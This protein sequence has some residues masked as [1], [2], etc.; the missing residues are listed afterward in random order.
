M[1]ARNKV[2][3]LRHRR[4]ALAW[5]TVALSV[6]SVPAAITVSPP[7]DTG[8]GSGSN[9]PA[10]A[11]NTATRAIALAE[12]VKPLRLT[13][14]LRDGSRILGVPAITNLQV[15]SSFGVIGIEL[16][17]LQTLQFIEGK[18]ASEFLLQNGDKVS[19]VLNLE[20]VEM[21]TSFGP[22][23][24]PVAAIRR[25]AVN[26]GGKSRGGLVLHYG[27]DQDE[28]N[29]VRDKSGQG[30]DGKLL[31]AQWVERGKFGGG[32]NISGGVQ[33]VTSTKTE[34]L[35]LD[36]Y[37]VA[38]WVKR[39]NPN[40]TSDGP[41]ASGLVGATGK[42]GL[43]VAEPD[44]RIHASRA[45]GSRA[46]FRASVADLLWHHLVLVRQVKTA[47]LFLD[48]EPAG[49]LETD[50]PCDLRPGLDIG[51][52]SVGYP[53]VGTLDEVMIFDRPLSAEE[54]KQ[55]ANPNP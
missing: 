52:A 11:T 30:H 6:S 35:R 42:T 46:P 49:E 39:S 13:L 10:A 29:L 2:S 4:F 1:N 18:D 34:Q 25:L 44:G 53:F 19:G 31:G 23:K 40:S 3:Q 48:G 17:R 37:S 21:K 9:P 41:Y 8:S 26:P 5:L 38:L 36:D 15:R 50:L 12:V 28:N 24:I 32:V 20:T 45:D 27:F 22:V 51:G 33:H 7:P 16:N 55:L 43:L 14:E 47:T 54:A